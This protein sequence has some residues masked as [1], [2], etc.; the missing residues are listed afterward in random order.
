MCTEA[1][2]VGER[3]NSAAC[4]SGNTSGEGA[5]TGVGGDTCTRVGAVVGSDMLMSV[6]DKAQED[7]VAKLVVVV[8]PM[9]GLVETGL[10]MGVVVNICFG[11]SW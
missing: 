2:G 10:A 6:E 3:S 1:A 8:A 11:N 9:T 4:P 5:C 7:D